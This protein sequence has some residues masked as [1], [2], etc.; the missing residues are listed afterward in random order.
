MA[1]ARHFRLWTC[2]MLQL[3]SSLMRQTQ[4]VPWTKGGLLS[5]QHFQTQD[6]F[7]ED[8]LEFQLSALAFSPW[9]F[10]R[11]E[12]NRE[13]LAAGSFALAEAAGILPDGLLFD[14]PASEPAPLPR[15]LEGEFLPDQPYL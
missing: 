4:P 5:P 7:L 12:I 14:M 6:R 10:K 8:L 2:R 11:L 9:G 3:A 13:A 1:G 15:P